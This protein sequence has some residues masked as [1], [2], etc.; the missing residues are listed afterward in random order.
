MARIVLL[1]AAGY[2]G[3]LI[4]QRLASGPAEV[5]LAGRAGAAVAALADELGAVCTTAA[6]R[7]DDPRTPLSGHDG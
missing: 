4:A 5:M 3:R 2:T 6:V 7:L 1:G